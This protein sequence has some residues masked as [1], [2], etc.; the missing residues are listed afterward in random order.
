M[1]S[2]LPHPWAKTEH[3]ISEW[4]FCNTLLKSHWLLSKLADAILSN[5]KSNGNLALYQAYSGFTHRET[6]VLLSKKV[7]I[8]QHETQVFLRQNSS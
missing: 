8:Y 6:Q 7:G 3:G 1:F 2:D 5:G 4:G